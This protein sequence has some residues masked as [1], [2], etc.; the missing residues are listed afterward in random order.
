MAKKRA[1][2]EGKRKVAIV[3]FCQ[4]SRDR[5]PY[6]DPDYEVWGLNRGYIFMP[7]ADRWFD[8]H[9]PVIRGA[10]TR[11]PGRHMDWLAR[12]PGPVYLHE[13][14][15]QVPTSVAFPLAEVAADVGAGLWRLDEQ[16][17]RADA[18]AVPYFDSSIA[19]EIGLA[20]HEGF[21]EICMVGVDLNTQG[22]YVWQRSGVSYL[23][24]VAMGRGIAVVLPD[25]CPILTGP[26]YG[27]GYLSSEGEH[28]SLA[29]LE[30]RVKALNDER[31][32]ELKELSQLTGALRELQFVIDQMVPGLD[33]ER[34]E[35]RRH[36]M[37]RAIAEASAKVER[38]TGA[39]KETLYWIHQTPGGQSPE[40]FARAQLDAGVHGYHRNGGEDLSEGDCSALAM[41]DAPAPELAAV[42]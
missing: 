34:M 16:G 33:H 19:Y 29:Q 20:I 25:N 27:R 18:R 24:G 36:E 23:L 37:E 15:P 39:I 21:D 8:L 31:N 1:P 30:T 35:R 9:S 13:A 12:F 14:D 7:R 32:H 40:E 3:G 4:T 22:E 11:R 42:N 17:E 2:R 41:L 10:E 38:V 6:D 28:M 5:V 26:L